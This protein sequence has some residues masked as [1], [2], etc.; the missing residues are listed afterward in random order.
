MRLE[1]LP[2]RIVESRTG[3][4]ALEIVRWEHLDLTLLDRL[5]PRPESPLNRQTSAL[6]ICCCEAVQQ[7]GSSERY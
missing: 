7:P 3:T 2:C 6:P 5:M 4:E 1:P